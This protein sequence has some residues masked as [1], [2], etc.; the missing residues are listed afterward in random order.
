[1]AWS[2]Q[3]SYQ[4]MKFGATRVKPSSQARESSQTLPS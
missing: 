3:A 4:E 1:M 2:S